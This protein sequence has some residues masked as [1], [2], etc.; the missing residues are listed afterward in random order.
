VNLVAPQASSFSRHED[1]EEIAEGP[2]KY[3]TPSHLR[4]FALII[5][6]RRPED[7]KIIS[8]NVLYPV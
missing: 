5:F 4:V 2:G 6:T 1:H 7:A 8:A 3:D